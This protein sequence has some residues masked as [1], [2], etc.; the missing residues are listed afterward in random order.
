MK[1]FIATASLLGVMLVPASAAFAADATTAAPHKEAPK[2]TLSA[3][4][5]LTAVQRAARAAA[6]KTYRDALKAADADRSAAV[7]AAHTAYT[8]A[9]KTAKAD[10]S[11]DEAKTAHTTQTAAV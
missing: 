1:K 5:K 8:A 6:L 9:L 10:K 7:K 4:P 3:A 2:T 11:K